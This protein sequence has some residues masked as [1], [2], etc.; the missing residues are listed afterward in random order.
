VSFRP[1]KTKP[2]LS[3]EPSSCLIVLSYGTLYH[4]CFGIA[5][6]SPPSLL[7]LKLN[8]LFTLSL[9]PL[10]RGTLENQAF[11]IIRELNNAS[12]DAWCIGNIHFLVW[13]LDRTISRYDGCSSKWTDCAISC[14]GVLRTI[15]RKLA[16]NVSQS[17]QKCLFEVSCADFTDSSDLHDIFRVKDGLIFEDLPRLLLGPYWYY[18]PVDKSF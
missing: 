8:P 5:W 11:I 3:Q 1:S 13:A 16:S 15:F 6:A 18:L 9:Y 2:F 7:F 17:Y 14:K 12:K 4:T 10:T